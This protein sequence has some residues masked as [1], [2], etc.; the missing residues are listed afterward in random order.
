MTIAAQYAP[1][2]V[3]MPAVGSFFAFESIGPESIEVWM[4]TETVVAGVFD[5]VRLPQSQYSAFMASGN[6]SPAYVGGLIVLAVGAVPNTVDQISIERNTPIKQ[7]ADFSN[8]EPFHMD[9]IEFALDKL[10]M[11]IQEIAV[12][13]CNVTPLSP[14]DIKQEL[15]WN[16][17]DVFYASMVDFALDKLISYCA[18]MVANG[19]DCRNDLEN[20]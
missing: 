10:T 1:V 15:T 19:N 4:E 6:S 16:R 9:M 12:R 17:Q 13:K 7:L 14:A 8:F 18:Q 2:K 3:L 5:R 11:I 20:T